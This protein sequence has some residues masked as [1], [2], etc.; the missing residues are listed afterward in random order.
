MSSEAWHVAVVLSPFV[1]LP[2]IAWIAGNRARAI[3][4]TTLPIALTAYFTYVWWLVATTGPFSVTT[5][6]A[7]SLGLSLSFHFDGLST[8]FAVMIT[9]IGTLIVPYSATYP[10]RTPTLD[11]ST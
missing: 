6:W 8:L 4:L 10:E 5:A 11:D 3:L 9:G 2:A 1:S 7:P